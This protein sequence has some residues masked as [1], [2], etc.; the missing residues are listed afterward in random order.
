MFSLHVI[1]INTG[2]VY[3][4]IWMIPMLD[5]FDKYRSQ[6]FRGFPNLK[7]LFFCGLAEDKS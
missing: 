5:V 7:I 1:T 2:I 3:T 4:V 6:R